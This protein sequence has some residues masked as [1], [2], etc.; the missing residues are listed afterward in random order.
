M[1]LFS[2][3]PLGERQGEEVSSSRATQ[4]RLVQVLLPFS[5]VKTQNFDS[6]Q[7]A[8]QNQ[9]IRIRSDHHNALD[10]S[11]MDLLMNGGKAMPPVR[12]KR[13]ELMMCVPHFAMKIGH[14]ID[15]LQILLGCFT[16]PF[17][18]ENTLL[19]LWL[20]FGC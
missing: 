12:I 11:A 7:E 17:D 10:L 19:L 18:S 1:R 4:V 5:P 14:A 16:K 6:P 9:R 3:S 20:R 13:S 2:L 8:L 15:A